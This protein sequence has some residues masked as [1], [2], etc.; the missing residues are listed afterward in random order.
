[1][2]AKSL[3]PVTDAILSVIDEYRSLKQDAPKKKTP[4]I[5]KERRGL[6]SNPVNRWKDRRNIRQKDFEGLFGG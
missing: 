5:L 4:G 6:Q 2:P 3:N 1:L